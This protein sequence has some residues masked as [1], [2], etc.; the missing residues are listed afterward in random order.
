MRGRRVAALAG[1][2][3]VIAGLAAACTNAYVLGMTD[4]RPAPGL[5]SDAA[6]LRSV[7]LTS[8][9]GVTGGTVLV[10]L[11]LVVQHGGRKRPPEE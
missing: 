11:G 4:A 8:L 9:I 1:P 6:R 5:A 10:V 2:V 3:L 7:R